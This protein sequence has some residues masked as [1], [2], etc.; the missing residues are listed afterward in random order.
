M[1]F[2]ILGNKRRIALT[3]KIY[4]LEQLDATPL[5]ALSIRKIH[6]DATECVEIRRASDGALEIFGFDSNGILDFASILAWLDGSDGFVRRWFDQSGNNVTV[7][8]T[9]A[10]AQ[11]QIQNTWSGSLPTLRWFTANT[12]FDISGITYTSYAMSFVMNHTDW[13]SEGVRAL[14]TKRPSVSDSR[15]LIFGFSSNSNNIT[16][17]QTTSGGARFN[18]GFLP[19]NNTNYRYL[20]NRPLSGTNRIFYV[21]GSQEASTS[22]NP[23]VTN[24]STL[25]LGNETSSLSNRGINSRFSEYLLF[26]DALSSTDRTILDSNQSIFYN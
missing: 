4:L 21:N 5:L 6:P 22:A 24:N 2:L 25:V 13:T 26:D 20:F 14:V 23:D 3:S 12:R 16:W 15:T 17:D 19:S 7:Q 8:Q 11:P 9:T 10:N 1:S 18:T